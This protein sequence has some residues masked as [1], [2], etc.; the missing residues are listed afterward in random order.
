MAP[1]QD[2]VAGVGVG[3]AAHVVHHLAGKLDRVERLRVGREALALLP[4]QAR[5]LRHQ[6]RV[7]HRRRRFVHAPVE[8]VGLQRTVGD[9]G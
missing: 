2:D 9:N 1:R 8:A 4:A 3:G 7:Q 5:Q 6:P